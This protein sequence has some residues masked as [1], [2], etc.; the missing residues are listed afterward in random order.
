[1]AKSVEEDQFEECKR[2]AANYLLQAAHDLVTALTWDD[3]DQEHFQKVAKMCRKEADRI[4][5]SG[6]HKDG[7][8]ILFPGSRGKTSPCP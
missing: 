8:V 1:M 6:E 4:F 3:T 7:K 5:P 2:R